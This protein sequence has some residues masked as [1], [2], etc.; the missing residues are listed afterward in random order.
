ME[1]YDYNNDDDT[2]SIDILSLTEPSARHR[3]DSSESIDSLMSSNVAPSER[4]WDSEAVTRP[5]LIPENAPLR[6]HMPGNGP[7]ELLEGPQAWYKPGLGG[8]FLNMNTSS[9]SA[10]LERML[11]R[12]SEQERAELFI[13]HWALYG[14]GYSA[15]CSV[16]RERNPISHSLAIRSLFL[17]AHIQARI[18]TTENKKKR[19]K[20]RCSLSPCVDADMSSQGSQDD[21]L[22]NSSDTS[23]D[24]STSSRGVRSS[25]PFCEVC[26]FAASKF[27]D[28][29]REN[30]SG[31]RATLLTTNAIL[32]V[33]FTPITELNNEQTI[34]KDKFES[35]MKSVVNPGVWMAVFASIEKS[36]YHTRRRAL[37]DI[38]GALIGQ[39]ANCESLVR[40]RNWQRFVLP[41][42]C[43]IPMPRDPYSGRMESKI[44]EKVFIFTINIYTLCHY[45]L[46]TR[47]GSDLT[48][49]GFLHQ[50]SNSLNIIKVGYA[51]DSRYFSN[52]IFKSFVNKVIAKRK[53]IANRVGG[54]VW[55]R[56]DAFLGY[57][58]KVVFGKP[59]FDHL[60][61]NLQLDDEQYIPDQELLATPGVSRQNTGKSDGASVAAA[62]TGRS[63]GEP[64]TSVSEY[65]DSDYDVDETFED[66]ESNALCRKYVVTELA[67]AR[68]AMK[69][70]TN[71]L[72]SSAE[73]NA[74]DKAYRVLGLTPAL[75][76][77]KAYERKQA[78]REAAAR[79]MYEE[80]D[81]V[82][83]SDEAAEVEEY[84]EVRTKTKIKKITDIHTGSTRTIM[85]SKTKLV[86][87]VTKSWPEKEVT[88]VYGPH[89]FSER[90][91]YA[92][93]ADRDLM[94]RIARFLFSMNFH[95]SVD[96]SEY[97]IGSEE[98][99]S[100]VL[101]F[102]QHAHFFADANVFLSILNSRYTFLTQAELVAVSGRFFEA[103]T[104]S[105][106]RKVFR[107]V[108]AWMREHEKERFIRLKK[109]S[110]KRVVAQ[111]R[112]LQ[113][114]L[115]NADSE[116][117][118]MLAEFRTLQQTL[119]HQGTEVN[120]DVTSQC[121][122]GSEWRL[123]D[124]VAGSALS[125][126][127]SDSDESPRDKSGKPRGCGGC[128]K[129]PRRKKD[130]LPVNPMYAPLAE[131]SAM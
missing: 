98:E 42:L 54:I 16:L 36:E 28:S 59:P 25:S 69:K 35:F 120:F 48:A 34:F 64:E 102:H 22:S 17:L 53:M 11:Y 106:R 24:T 62:A 115:A 105:A 76:N 58:K 23:S 27:R 49:A 45:H 12:M 81:S 123:K 92:M 70:S 14:V 108:D 50:F 121:D 67:A 63:G 87:K 113:D 93:K 52:A 33:L 31:N 51:E 127:H 66:L 6:V 91:D 38:N 128:F 103:E 82:C 61:R 19:R 77:A 37:K 71:D 124:C 94:H 125:L 116:Q 86:T 3:R 26:N 44:L 130:A 117:D 15:I 90:V 13:C 96:G 97:P 74:N 80:E 9:P 10:R 39:P 21:T 2:L 83:E 114:G 129:S 118:L 57:C 75:V 20:C 56:L 60:I 5:L 55:E 111:A 99:K 126:Q 4:W 30:C 43:D 131:D 29:I 32:S 65:D 47:R 1:T 89:W 122:S 68:A 109:M 112:L 119:V 110:V 46:L 88:Q 73:H 79:A 72:P 40:L 85:T 8:Q 41:L 78:Q 101:R 18:P 100:L 95:K 107:N 84:T 104:T 7:A